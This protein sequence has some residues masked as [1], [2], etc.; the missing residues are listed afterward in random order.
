MFIFWT[1]VFKIVNWQLKDL[2]KKFPGTKT[3]NLN[4]W[5][6]DGAFTIPPKTIALKNACVWSVVGIEKKSTFFV[7][8]THEFKWLMN[9]FIQIN[10]ILLNI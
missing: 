3:N 8:W 2:E 5:I 7:V 10:I 6:Q 4:K 1:P 9:L